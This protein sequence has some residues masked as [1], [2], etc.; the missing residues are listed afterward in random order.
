ML[1]VGTEFGQYDRVPVMIIA[2]D[3]YGLKY[4]VVDRDIEIYRVSLYI[5]GYICMIETVCKAL[6]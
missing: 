1:V 6:R 2:R 5:V 4:I 3:L